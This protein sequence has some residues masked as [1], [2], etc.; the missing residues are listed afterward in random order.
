MPSTAN[1]RQVAGDHYG[2]LSYQH[3]DWVCDIG[4]HYLLACATKYVARWRNKNGLE[5]LEKARHYIQKASER[6]PDLA[7]FDEKSLK[8]I[9]RFA[10][11]LETR[12]AIIVEAIVLRQYA[13]A[14]QL[15]AQLIEETLQESPTPAP[16]G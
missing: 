16:Q 2:K 7:A 4:L 10:G 5:D 14:D 13:S 9:A 1:D 8:A 15:I 6:L 12:D 3:W 11:G